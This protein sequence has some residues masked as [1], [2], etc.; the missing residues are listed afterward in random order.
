MQLTARGGL[1]CSRYQLPVPLPEPGPG[2][3][4]WFCPASPCTCCRTPVVSRRAERQ[5]T[6]FYFG[7]DA[8]LQY[9]RAQQAGDVHRLL[10]ARPAGRR[11][12]GVSLLGAATRHKRSPALRVLSIVPGI[13]R[14]FFVGAGMRCWPATH[15]CPSLLCLAAPRQEDSVWWQ[16]DRSGRLLGTLRGKDGRRTPGDL[17]RGKTLRGGKPFWKK[18]LP[19]RAPP[20]QKLLPVG[21]RKDGKA[22]REEGATPISQG[23]VTALQKP[24]CMVLEGRDIGQREL[25]CADRRALLVWQQGTR[26]P[27]KLPV[28]F[29][30]SSPS[31]S[32]WRWWRGSIPQN[33]NFLFQRRQLQKRLPAMQAVLMSGFWGGRGRG[34]G[35]PFF[36]PGKGGPS[37]SNAFLLEKTCIRCRPSSFTASL[38]GIGSSAS[39][40]FFY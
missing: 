5:G 31:Y 38:K 13:S 18:V 17:K 24:E 2:V 20:F 10:H 11:P 12:Y 1:F 7:R 9:R 40:L 6:F 14:G 36:P 27:F 39:R 29:R 32:W 4:F 22:R 15:A 28:H 34:G 19:P 16:A 25:G 21:L 23:H 30:T 26:C 33:G 8:S 35:N 37:P 3:V